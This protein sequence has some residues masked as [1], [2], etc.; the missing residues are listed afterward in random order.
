MTDFERDLGRRWFEEVWNN[1]RRDAIAQMLAPGAVIHD[2]ASDAVGADGFYAFYDRLQVALSDIHV[3]VQDSIAEGDKVCV[4]WL[5]TA[6]HTGDGLGMPATGKAV[7]ITG[8]SIL[9]VAHNRLV[10]GWQNWDMLGLMEQIRGGA[11]SATYI[12]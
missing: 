5:C 11:R 4:R 8:I 1:G 3:E 9:R 2:G 7:R 12:S 6:K 10:E